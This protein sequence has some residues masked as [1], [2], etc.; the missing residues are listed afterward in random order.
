MP[1][2]AAGRRNL[3]K[4]KH[5]QTHIPVGQS[6]FKH[7]RSCARSSRSFHVLTNGQFTRDYVRKDLHVLHFTFLDLVDIARSRGVEK[8]I[9]WIVDSDQFPRLA[10]ASHIKR[11]VVASVYENQKYNSFSFEAQVCIILYRYYQQSKEE[12]YLHRAKCTWFVH[13][14]Q[15]VQ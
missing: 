9:A 5:R 6:R 2:Y 10:G 4:T 12:L 8:A 1:I 7:I 3:C 15:R 14:Q 13:L 11:N